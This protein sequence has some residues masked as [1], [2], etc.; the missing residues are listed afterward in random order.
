M[1]DLV[2]Q[3]AAGRQANTGGAC[4]VQLCARFATNGKTPA[5]NIGNHVNLQA[6][7]AGKQACKHRRGMQLCAR[8]AA[9]RLC[10][11]VCLSM[12]LSTLW[13]VGVSH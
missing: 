9:K 2:N 4:G 6:T 11:P 12:R 13:V 10:L 5:Y 3:H 8:F 1:N 7:V